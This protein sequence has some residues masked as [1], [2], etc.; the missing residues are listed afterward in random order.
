MRKL[1]IPLYFF[2]LVGCR[3]ELPVDEGSPRIVG[4]RIEGSVVDSLDR[5]IGDVSVRLA[6]TYIFIDSVLPESRQLIVPHTGTVKIKIFDMS[7]SMIRQLFAGDVGPG[8]IYY[9]WD[10][11]DSQRRYVGSGLYFYSFSLD[12]E[13]LVSYPIL[14][15]S[16]VTT[17]TENDGYFAIEDVHFPIG[18]IVPR[19]SK[20]GIFGGNFLIFNTVNLIFELDAHRVVREVTLHQSQVVTL[21][22]TL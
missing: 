22:Q 15:D 8:E 1:L 6:Y 14:I 19:F 10:Y 20:E 7:N 11:R 21:K 3:E 17:S 4:Y 18:A 16:A 12:E 5:G 2:A 9:P 13:E